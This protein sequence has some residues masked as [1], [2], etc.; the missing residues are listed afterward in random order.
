M[1]FCSGGRLSIG[2]AGP[3][4][5]VTRHAGRPRRPHK[6]QGFRELT[7]THGRRAVPPRIGMPTRDS[8]VTFDQKTGSKR[9]LKRDDVAA[10]P[11]SGNSGGS[12][13]AIQKVGGPK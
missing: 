4:F 3:A 13:P 6:I 8:Y 5:T 2:V 11:G 7:R 10:V 12:A 9:V 1:G